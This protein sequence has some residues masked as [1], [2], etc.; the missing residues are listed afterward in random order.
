MDGLRVGLLIDR[1]EPARGGAEAA[2]AALG[3]HLAARGARVVVASATLAPGALPPGGEWAAVRPVG[4]AARLVARSAAERWLA[5]DLADAARGCDVTVGVRHLA[6]VDL[7]WPHGGSHGAS[8]AARRASRGQR[9]DGA[10]RGRHRAFLALERALLAGGGARRVACVSEL[11]RDEL[12]RAYPSAAERLVVVPNGVDRARFHPRERERSRAALL[13]R[14]GLAPAPGTCVLS[15]AARE[16]RLKGLPVLLEALAR[17]RRDDWALV[18]AGMRDAE[19]WAARARRLGLPPERCAFV[20]DADPV[21]LAAGADLCALPTWRDTSSLVAL[22]A[23]AAG[24]PV[25]TTDRCGAATAVGPDAGALVPAGD[26]DALASALEHWIERARTGAI[27]RESIG[28]RVP[29]R[30]TWLDAL[31]ALVEELAPR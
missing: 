13:A 22:E 16:P 28:A 5:R 9:A 30:A 15:F 31:A 27:D 7:Y 14:A 24:T 26:A 11:V 8:L 3:E 2:L 10:V 21:D 20:P 18:A 19:R 12:E 25:V 1:F 23:L 17:L 6:R 29:D 4:R